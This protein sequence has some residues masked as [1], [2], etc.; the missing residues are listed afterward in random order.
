MKRKSDQRKLADE[1]ARHLFT[2]GPDKTNP[3]VQYL[4]LTNR[5]HSGIDDNGS[6]CQSAVSDVIERYLSNGKWSKKKR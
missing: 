6:W 3:P 2:P 4:M 5:A 1:I